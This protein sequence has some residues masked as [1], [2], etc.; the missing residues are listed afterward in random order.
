MLKN[1]S[2][3]N[4]KHVKPAAIA[5]GVS[6]LIVLIIFHAGFFSAVFW[7]AIIAIAFF[8]YRVY[9]APERMGADVEDDVPAVLSKPAEKADAPKAEAAPK[10]ASSDAEVVSEAPK[11]VT[12]PKAAPKAKSDAPKA[13]AK[14]AAAKPAKTASGLLT[15]PRDGGADDLKK[16]SGVGPVLEAKLNALG[17]YHFDQ[18]A[19][20]KKAD[21]AW[22]DDQ[23]NFKGRIDRDG[24]VAQAKALMKG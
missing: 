18:I 8:A 15:A 3:E 21:I 20:L 6:F 13:A 17:I 9:T 14:P 10:A 1:I 4:Q 11:P 19:G 7:G 22:V 24:W 16:I 5:G 12:K 2:A 23:L